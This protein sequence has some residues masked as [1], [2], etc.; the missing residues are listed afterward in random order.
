MLA[1]LA[2][3]LAPVSISE[4][5][6]VFRTRKRL[7]I[8]ASDP[9]RAESLFSWPDIETMLS[10]HALDESITLMRDGVIVPR[11][12]Y[13]SNE[14]NRLNVRALHDILSQ[15]ASIV[16]DGV[17]RLIPQIRHLAAAVEREMGILTQVN[18][19]LSFSKGGAFKPHWDIHDIL[20]VQIHGNKR[21]HVWKAEVPNPVEMADQS[22]VNGS[23][24]PDQEI[25]M[26]PGD[27]LFVPRGE[28]H[29]AAVSIKHSAHLTIGLVS[30]T[31]INFLD[32]L[33]KEAIKDPI[34]RMD[35]PRHSSEEESRAHEIA[36]KHQLH[37]LIDAASMSDFLREGDLSRKPVLQT[38]VSGVLPQM[39]DTLRLTLRRRIP[40]PDLA[41]DGGMQSL[42][43]DGESRRLSPAS[44]DV[45]RWL[46]DHDSATLR[47]LHVGLTALHG[48]ASVETAIRELL[49]HGFLVV[50]RASH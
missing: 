8:A 43:I 7:H 37:K 16:V 34:L 42:T 6:D 11:H 29:S 1:T 45:L 10:E 22:H 18:A 31:G 33:R 5:L 17:N 50:N 44:I 41:P 32:H 30:Q 48:Q 3:L 46:F 49:R 36:L 47:A 13:T 14:G 24:P 39:E 12:F 26:L 4:F 21:W 28:P 40:L 27:I 20:I 23:V 35:L 19:Y 15:G 2:D 38:A 9:G 25:E